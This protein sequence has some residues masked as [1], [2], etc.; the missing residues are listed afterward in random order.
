MIVDR[1]EVLDLIRR[2][3]TL[4]P[5]KGVRGDKETIDLAKEWLNILKN[6]SAKDIHEAFTTYAANDSK[7][8]KNNAPKPGELIAIHAQGQREK[9]QTRSWDVTDLCKLCD[10]ADYVLV[11]LP[12]ETEYHELGMK[13]PHHYADELRQLKG[14]GKVKRKLGKRGKED[15]MFYFAELEFWLH[16]DRF[17]GRLEKPYQNSVIANDLQQGQVEQRNGFSDFNSIAEMEFGFDDDYEP[18]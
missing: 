11:D 13:C 3:D 18:F 1:Q 4:Y 15:R 9:R 5:P 2:I 12:E 17:F 7:A 8:Y 16:N 6:Y 10:G 14:G